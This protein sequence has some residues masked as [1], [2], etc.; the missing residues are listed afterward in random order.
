[1]QRSSTLIFLF[2]FLYYASLCI[3][4][5]A[6]G[7]GKHLWNIW[8]TLQ[9]FSWITMAGHSW[10]EGMKE[11]VLVSIP[12]SA[13]AVRTKPL[14]TQCRS[15]SALMIRCDKPVCETCHEK[16]YCLEGSQQIPRGLLR[17][18]PQWRWGRLLCFFFISLWPSER[19]LPGKSSQCGL[20]KIQALRW[21]SGLFIHSVSL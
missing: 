3:Y 2:P 14:A 17:F 15:T 9:F 18:I 11:W 5:F 4:E 20:M 21:W 13:L 6:K 1:M 19:H 16:Y 8:A 7:D 10:R 12:A